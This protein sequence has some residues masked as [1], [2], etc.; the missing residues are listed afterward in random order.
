MDS[1]ERLF[2]LFSFLVPESKLD[3]AEYWEY[4]RDGIGHGEILRGIFD[5]PDDS[6]GLFQQ[7][8]LGLIEQPEWIGYDKPFPG[9]TEKL[10]EL[11]GRYSLVMVTARQSA[12]V[13]KEQIGKFGW[14]GLFDHV[15]VTGQEM[16]KKDLILNRVSVTPDDWFIGDTGIDIQTGKFLKIK[17][18][19]VLSGFRNSKK[20]EKY[21]PDVIIDGLLDFHY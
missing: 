3:F 6:I 7:S 19:A 1:K 16:E 9:I 13:V 20:L 11:T 14:E 12:D 5:Y 2:Q 18:A 8:W 17:T 4:K 15:L 10:V 21:H